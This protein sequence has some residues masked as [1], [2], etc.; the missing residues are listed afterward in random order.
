M[1]RALAFLAAAAGVIFAA[2]LEPRKDAGEYPASARTETLAIGAE[3][4]VHSLSASGQTW[5]V[6]DYL[7]VEVAAFPLAKGEFALNAGNFSL[8]ING[9]K[10]PILP[11]TPGIVAA[12]LKY[13]DWE[14]RSRVEAGAGVGGAD[15]I[16]GRPQPVERFPGDTRPGRQRLPAPPRAPDQENPSGLD[17]PRPV[18]AGEAVQEAA[19]PEGN[20]RGPIAGYLYFAYKGKLKSIRS[21]ELL[22]SGPAGPASLQLR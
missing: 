18:S 4:L 20:F 9:K 1:L 16:L 12:S 11:Q 10:T 17:K 3:Y 19:L 13:P 7:I 15:V 21:L 14:E 6:P 2:G 8:R 5:F 22:Y